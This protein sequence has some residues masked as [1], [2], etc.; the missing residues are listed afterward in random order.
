MEQE[1]RTYHESIYLPLAAKNRPEYRE[2]K[3]LVVYNLL[4]LSKNNRW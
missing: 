3:K 2:E 4:G 1:V